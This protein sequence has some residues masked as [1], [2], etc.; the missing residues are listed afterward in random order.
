MG[1]KKARSEIH[2]KVR[3]IQ[4]APIIV[5]KMGNCYSLNLDLLVPSPEKV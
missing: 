1:D 3:D 5:R 4:R 2:N